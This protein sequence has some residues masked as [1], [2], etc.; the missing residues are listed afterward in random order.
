M[1]WVLVL[2]FHDIFALDGS[3]LGCISMVEHEIC[4]TDSKPFK[5]RF[6]CIPPLLLEEVHTSLRDMLDAWA[7]HPSQSPWCNTVVLVRKK[8]GM[9]CFCVDLRRLN[10]HTKKDSYPLPQIQEALE[11][12]AGATHISMMDFKSRFWQVKMVPESQ[13]YTT[14][15]VGNL[16]FDVFTRMPFG[17]CNALATF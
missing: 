10:T 1:A 14:F 6:R 12:M 17:L 16:G 9:L 7:I 3:E 4:I 15:T 8:D 11:S 5:K 13:Q 2:A